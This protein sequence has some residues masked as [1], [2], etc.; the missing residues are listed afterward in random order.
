[1][2]PSKTQ[3]L[4]LGCQQDGC[5]PGKSLGIPLEDHGGGIFLRSHPSGIFEVKEGALRETMTLYIKKH[6][7]TEA[8]S[9]YNQTFRSAYQFHLDPRIIEQVSVV[10]ASTWNQQKRMFTTKG[11]DVFDGFVQ[12]RM[13]YKRTTHEFLVACGFTPQDGEWICMASRLHKNRDI[14]SAAIS[15]D[16]KR[17]RTLCVMA[18]QRGNTRL[19]TPMVRME[20]LRRRPGE[21]LL[22]IYLE[23]DDDPGCFVM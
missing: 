2:G 20:I 8:G 21:S 1:M 17:M 10:P 4:T 19:G 23:A 6:M 15:G 18:R 3:F 16:L 14:Y 22:H 9:E 13:T 12:F 11:L 7:H 5:D